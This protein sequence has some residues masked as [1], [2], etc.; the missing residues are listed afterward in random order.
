MANIRIK[1]GA[2]EMTANGSA[3]LIAQER[4]ALIDF[5]GQRAGDIWLEAKERRDKRMA[6][7]AKKENQAADEEITAPVPVEDGM[8]WNVVAIYD[9]AG[10]PSI[11]HRF[12]RVTNKELFG[13]SDKVHPAFIIGGEVYDEIFISVYQNTMIGDKPYSLPG[14]KPVTNITQEDF[15]EL[16]FSKG[17]GWHCLTAAEWGLLANIS[18]KLGTLPHGNTDCGRWHGDTSE[19]GETV[20]NGGMTATGTGPVTWTHDHTATGVHDLCGNIWEFARG[21]RILDG[22]LQ[23]AENNDAALPETDLSEGGTGW[24]PITDNEGKPVFV[25]VGREKITF[26]TDSKI[27]GDYTGIPWE[28]VNM[29]CESEQL[30]ALAFYAGEPGA[31]CF[32]DSA[33]GEYILFR[34]GGW[35]DGAYAGVFYSYLVNARSYADGSLGGRSA[36]FKKH[37]NAEH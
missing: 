24:K 21:M 9:N 11:M 34:G 32:V 5:L 30:K 4:A 28:R 20:G 22:A 13:G 29:D 18:A 7:A 25:S 1:C 16:C 31:M 23:A 35:Y 10:I 12:R 14:A 27:K 33:E 37:C 15:A 8:E 26:T 36:F 6:E 2:I 19:K 3:E 17:E